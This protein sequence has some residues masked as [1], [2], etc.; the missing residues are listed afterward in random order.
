MP[1]IVGYSKGKTGMDEDIILCSRRTA[2]QG[3]IHAQFFLT[4]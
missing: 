2:R 1:V 4:S 3:D